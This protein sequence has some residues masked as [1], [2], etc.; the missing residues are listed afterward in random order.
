LVA[1]VFR[2]LRTVYEA[3]VT[4]VIVLSVFMLPLC[5][6]GG[7]LF[8]IDMIP[9]GQLQ[10]EIGSGS[11]ERF[12]HIS[13]PSAGDPEGSREYFGEERRMAG[14]YDVTPNRIDAEPIGT[15]ATLAAIEKSYG[16]V[17]RRGGPA[18]GYGVGGSTTLPRD[19]G[20]EQAE[21]AA[22]IAAQR[23]ANRKCDEPLPGI[24]HLGGDNYAV[25]RQVV[26][27]FSSDLAAVQRVVGVRWYHD[28]AG[29]VE[30]FQ[31]GNIRCGSPLDQL[32]IRNGDVVVRIDG[33]QVRSLMA[34]LGALRAVRRSERLRVDLIRKGAPFVRNVLID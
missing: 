34:A 19:D 30:G 25:Q 5:M 4:A 31:V 13:L 21:R 12:A 22:G 23:A 33:R 2:L 17:S 20:S 7:T 24:R 29:K 28:S 16:P 15:T 6:S 18:A 9:G 26:E 1:R 14:Q 32:G 8:R 10:A 3:T 27:Y 11:D